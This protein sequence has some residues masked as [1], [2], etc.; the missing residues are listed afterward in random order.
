[1]SRLTVRPCHVV[2]YVQLHQ[3]VAR[4]TIGHAATY[5]NTRLQDFPLL[6]YALQLTKK[7]WI[8]S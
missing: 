1:M 4:I 6:L 5:D 8:Q 2:T 7:Q 3:F